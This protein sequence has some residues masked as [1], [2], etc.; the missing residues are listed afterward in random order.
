MFYYYSA[1]LKLE[2]IHL[3]EMELVSLL[4]SY[5]MQLCV[6]VM[7]IDEKMYA[8]FLFYMAVISIYFRVTDLQLKKLYL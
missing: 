3:P 4:F 8:S 1:W 6:S 5:Y 7:M 2:Y